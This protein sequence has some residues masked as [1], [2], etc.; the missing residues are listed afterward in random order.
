MAGGLLQLI[1]KGIIDAYL[2]EDPQITFFK[3]IYRRH[4]NFAIESIPQN[5]SSIPNFGETVSCIL[6]KS[7]DLI[8]EIFLYIELPFIPKTK[9]KVAWVPYIGYAIIKDITISIGDKQIDKQYGEWLYIWSQLTD[10][11]INK[12]IGNVPILYD[13]TN[14]KPSYKLYIPLQFWFCKNNG[15]AL[16]I[17]A[18]NDDIK[19]TITLRK[20]EE[21]L[22]IGPTNSIK[23]KEDIIPF[24]EGDY[25]IQGENIGYMI[26]YDYITNKLYYNKLKG[27]FDNKKIYNQKDEYVKPNGIE[28]NEP[29]INIKLKITN[30]YLYVNYIYLD[31]EE[32]NKFLNSK[33]EYLIE[34]IQY[35]EMNI[36]SPNIKQKIT[37]KNPIKAYYWIIQL[38]KFKKFDL[39][40]FTNSF[41]KTGNLLRDAKLIL[42]GFD[43]FNQRDVSYFNLIQSFQHHKKGADIG[44]NVFSPSINPEEHQPS[45]TINMS[46]IDDIVMIMHLDPIINKND[47]AKIR[48]Y[49]IGYNILRILFNSYSLV[50]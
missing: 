42:N 17:L 4:T 27:T 30:S 46:K 5:F 23:I 8:G 36:D 6:S 28:E 14:E 47:P 3:K 49:A 10:K 50:F 20:L 1:A 29:I 16:P 12:I 37:L 7:G 24:N 39:F 40:N 31:T 22:I 25:L 43:R 33:I 21:V 2:T 15:L 32:R 44:I 18:L 13:F 19:I 26:D 38:D 48:S 9:N 34:Q 41:Y 45:S 11:K 35:N